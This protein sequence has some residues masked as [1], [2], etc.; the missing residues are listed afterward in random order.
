VFNLA[1]IAYVISIPLNYLFLLIYNPP[2]IVGFAFP[3]ALVLA[4]HRSK[5]DIAAYT[6]VQ[7]I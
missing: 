1:Y 2:P 5:F 3:D 7:E 6:Q 4:E